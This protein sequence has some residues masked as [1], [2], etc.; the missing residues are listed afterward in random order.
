MRPYSIPTPPELMKDPELA[1][2]AVLDATLDITWYA[3]MAE[4]PDMHDDYQLY[5]KPPPPI[6]LFIAR[7]IIQKMD[8]LHDAIVRYRQRLKEQHEAENK[9]L[10]F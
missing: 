2:L 8:E 6:S 5:D 4:Y 9:D 10:P 1:T 7:H 3:M